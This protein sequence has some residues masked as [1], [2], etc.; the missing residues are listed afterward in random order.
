LRWIGAGAQTAYL[1]QETFAVVSTFGCFVQVTRSL[2]EK[3]S[4]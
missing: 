1:A 3:A 2:E 4:R